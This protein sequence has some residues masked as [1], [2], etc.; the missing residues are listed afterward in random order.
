MSKRLKVL[1]TGATGNTCSSLVPKLLRTDVDVR[2]FIRDE[3]KA[4]QLQDSGAEVVIGDLDHPETIIHAVRD[5]DKIYLLTWNGPTQ[6]QQ[7]VNVI[8]TASETGNPH[9]VRHSMWGPKNSRIIKQGL[10][11][12]EIVKS[13]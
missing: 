7:A 5:V 10:E 9:I 13:S 6:L 1:V 4:K 12:E 3:G 8:K 2:L 11:V